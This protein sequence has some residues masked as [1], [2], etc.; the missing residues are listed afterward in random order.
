MRDGRDFIELFGYDYINTCC[1]QVMKIKNI[2]YR[3]LVQEKKDFIIDEIDDNH[4]YYISEYLLDM[5]I[6]AVIKKQ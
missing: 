3:I 6:N 2:D 1:L 5:S 4:D